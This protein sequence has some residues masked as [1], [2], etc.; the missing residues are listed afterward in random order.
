[1]TS[2]LARLAAAASSL[3]LRIV[4]GAVAAL[5]LGIGLVTMF[6][7]RQAESHTLAM[8]QE[9]QLGEVAHTATVLSHRVVELQRALKA[10]GAHIDRAMASDEAAL[11]R[12]LA[13]KPVLLVMF[14]DIAWLSPEGRMRVYVGPDGARHPDL[15]IHDRPYFRQTMLE[16]RALV[17]EPL[18]SRVVNSPL[19]VFTEPLQDAN[20]VYGVLGASLQLASYGL[21][22]QMVGGSNPGSGAATMIVTDAYGRIIAGAPADRLM[23]SIAN[24]PRF[25]AAYAQWREGGGVAE[26]SGQALQQ[27]GLLVSIAGV[28]GP[29]WVVWR[30]EPVS[31]LLAPLHDARRSAL[32]VAAALIALLSLGAWALL[33]RLLRPLEQLEDRAR[34]LFDGT[35]AL[36]DGW[37]RVRGEIGALSDVL[38]QAASERAQFEAVNQLMVKK[39]ESVMAAAP[40]GIAF[41]RDG[42]FELVSAEFCRLFGRTEPELLGHDAHELHAATEDERRF[43]EDRRIAFEAA[44]GYVGEW[45]MRRADGHVFWARLRGRVI[46]AGSPSG[47]AIWTVYDIED[48]VVRREQLE[49]SATHDRLT[50]VANRHAFEAAL[51]RAFA[52]RPR[53]MPAAVALIDLDRFKPVNDAAGHAAGDAVLKAVAQA[54]GRHVRHSD[55]VARIG[56]DEFALLLERCDAVAALRVAEAV[57]RAVHEVVVTW[58]ERELRVG[59]S[60]GVAP[61]TPEMDDVATW[62]EAADAARYAA[63][64]GGRGMVRSS[65]TIVPGTVAD[66]RDD[67]LDGTPVP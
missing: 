43:N 61:L 3:Q 39:L 53:S 27:P 12:A 32:S 55:L 17:S 5:A 42:R 45:R 9:R 24:E 16:Q 57:R 62:L 28:P 7:V 20:G 22:E 30:A 58:G 51:V 19:V 21:I 40:V 60:V 1:M 18:P 56:G 54:I 8:Q 41:T 6:A 31:E 38:R 64:A 11:T 47:G 4:L 63:K 67:E 14:S 44:G 23:S 26:T 13:T 34:H 48:E 10:T 50:G 59:A 2:R 25:A 36:P 37:P 49:W 29:D 66:A 33:S 15:D 35:L 52:A 46:D 65:V